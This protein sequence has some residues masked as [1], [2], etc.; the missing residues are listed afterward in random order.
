MF[1]SIKRDCAG[2]LGATLRTRSPA[3]IEIEFEIKPLA[4]NRDGERALAEVSRILEGLRFCGMNAC[5]CAECVR[6]QV[7]AIISHCS[8]ASCEASAVVQHSNAEVSD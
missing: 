5:I 7:R 1:I 3:G 2:A 8:L 6:H 4:E